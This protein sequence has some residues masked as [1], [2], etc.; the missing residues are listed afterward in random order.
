MLSEADKMYS[1]NQSILLEQKVEK[2]LKQYAV[3]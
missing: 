3:N 2:T 1:E